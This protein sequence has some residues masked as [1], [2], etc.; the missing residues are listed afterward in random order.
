MALRKAQ[1]E[2]SVTLFT[3]AF[4]TTEDKQNRKEL[5]IQFCDAF[6]GS[7]CDWKETVEQELGDEHL[8][9]EFQELCNSKGKTEIK[10]Y[11]T[12]EPLAVDDLEQI[13]YLARKE[14][15]MLPWI[16][17]ARKQDSIY[18]FVDEGYSF[19]A[20][21]ENV[22]LGFILAHK[23]PTYGGYYYLY[24]DTF[25][26]GRDAQGYGIGKM[27]LSKIREN[28]FENGIFSVKLMTQ[29]E[30]NA[31]QIYKHLGFEEMEDYVHMSKY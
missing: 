5:F 1:K 16:R 27:L 28:M 22:I 10:K 30:K 4:S 31:Y 9:A 13:T 6:D 21:R 8:R 15:D 24:V 23:C 17:D 20:K 26:V 7:I 12:I 29:R 2:M 19:V 14:L 3:K 25:V 18:D 11:V